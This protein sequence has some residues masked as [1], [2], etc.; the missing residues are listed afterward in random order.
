M[1]CVISN[2]T[3]TTGEVKYCPLLDNMDTQQLALLYDMARLQLVRLLNKIY[4]LSA[5]HIDIRT[6]KA[7]VREVETESGKLAMI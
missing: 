3:Y 7:C 2:H 5:L 1:Y 4:Y 6:N